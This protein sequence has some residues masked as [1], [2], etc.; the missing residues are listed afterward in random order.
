LKHRVHAAIDRYGLQAAGISDL[1][2]VK[3]RA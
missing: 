1:F 2:S 3:G